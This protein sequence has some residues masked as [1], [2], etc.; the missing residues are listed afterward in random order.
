MELRRKKREGVGEDENEEEEGEKKNKKNVAPLTL[1][2]NIN[3]VNILTFA[4]LDRK[5]THLLD[6][7]CC[8]LNL[9]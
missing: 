6:Y 7:F 8:C 4:Q 1:N 5:R 9:S 2:R 3:L